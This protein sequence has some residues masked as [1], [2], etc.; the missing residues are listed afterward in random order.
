MPSQKNV[1]LYFYVQLFYHI[2]LNTLFYLFVKHY[3]L[4]LKFHIF[5]MQIEI[6]MIFLIQHINNSYNVK[7]SQKNIIFSLKYLIKMK[8]M[9]DVI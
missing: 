4:G 3:L 9:Y 7:N 8:K 1:K 2:F 5:E 6:D